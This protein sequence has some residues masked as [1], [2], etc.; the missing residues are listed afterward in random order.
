MKKTNYERKISAA[1]NQYEAFLTYFLFDSKY[2]GNIIA[3]ISDKKGNEHV[4]ILDRGTVTKDG[5][6]LSQLENNNIDSFIKCIVDCLKTDN[7]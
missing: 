5:M 6:F 3:N 7:L 2:F 1:L 4:F